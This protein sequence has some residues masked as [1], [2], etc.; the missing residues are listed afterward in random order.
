MLTVQQL[1]CVL[2]NREIVVRIPVGNRT[3]LQVVQ[4]AI[5]WLPRVPCLDKGV[6]RVKLTISR[7]CRG[8]EWLERLHFPVCYQGVQGGSFI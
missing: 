3:L 6:R 8:R 1:T 7:Y 2:D 4:P 5:Y